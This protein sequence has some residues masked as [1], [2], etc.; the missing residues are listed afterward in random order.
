MK[1]DVLHNYQILPNPPARKDEKLY[2]ACKDFEAI[3]LA[4]LWREMKKTVPQHEEENTSHLSNYEE[5]SLPKFMQTLSA[6]GGIGLAD[7]LYRQL[8]P[9]AVTITNNK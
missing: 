8:A 6:G 1:I 4:Q 9:K 5:I 7:L 2:Q 3:F